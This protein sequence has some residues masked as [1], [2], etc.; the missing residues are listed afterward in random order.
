MAVNDSYKF[1]FSIPVAIT[2]HHKFYN[3]ELGIPY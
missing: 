2:I 1:T 3:K